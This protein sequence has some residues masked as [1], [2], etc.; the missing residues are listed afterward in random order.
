[1]VGV[2]GAPRVREFAHS[3]SPMAALR[4]AHRGLADV[5]EGYLARMLR[6]LRC[7]GDH[8]L[9]ATTSKQQLNQRA[10]DRIPLRLLVLQQCGVL[11]V[12]AC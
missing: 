3:L 9:I 11:R 10:P 8:M 6:H 4:P 7:A 5:S 1:V 12:F 2:C